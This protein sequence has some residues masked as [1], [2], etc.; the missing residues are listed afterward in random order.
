M[1][2]RTTFNLPYDEKRVHSALEDLK[3]SN[4]IANR[5]ERFNELINKFGPNSSILKNP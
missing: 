3:N 1:E 2:K 4:P 5:S